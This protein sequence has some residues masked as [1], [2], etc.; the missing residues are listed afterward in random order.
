LTQDLAKALNRELEG[1]DDAGAKYILVEEP[2]LTKYRKEGAQFLECAELLC[3]GIIASTMLGTSGGDVL[4][5]EKILQKSPFNGIAFD[6][7]DGPDNE[8]LLTDPNDTDEASSAPH[9]NS[10][11]RW[12]EKIIQ[13]GLINAHDNNVETSMEI[14]LELVK[15]G[16]YNNPGRIWVAPA[17]GLS[18]INREAAFKKLTN[19]CQ[20]AEWA[21]R[22]MA[23]REEPGGFLNS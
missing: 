4:G 19:M 12:G 5:L 16:T 11:D 13:L 23:R 6:M 10:S 18:E 3:N 21:R 17:S 9:P 2:L 14:A 22:E 7:I 1:L 20:G 15:Y 8:F